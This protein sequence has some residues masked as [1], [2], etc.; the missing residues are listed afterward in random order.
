MRIECPACE[1]RYEVPDTRLAPGRPVRC[2]RCGRDWTP[3]AASP[4]VPP[5]PQPP[6]V[7]PSGEF[8][9]SVLDEPHAVPI[10]PPHPF[11]AATRPPT[12]SDDLLP[13]A[14]GPKRRSTALVAAWVVSVAAV[15]A[16][17]VLAVVLREPIARAWPPSM[18]VYDALG[19]PVTEAR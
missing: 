5:S 3:L 8:T 1:A 2:A 12:H 13:V 19:L 14:V 9:A 6:A 11:I 4:A 10:R 17:V 7:A 16:A 18:R 15:V